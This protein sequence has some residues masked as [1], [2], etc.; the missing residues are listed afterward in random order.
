MHGWKMGLS[1]CALLASAALS[2]ATDFDD[3][4]TYLM[5]G[6]EDAVKDLEPVLGA[7]NAEAALADA[8]V[9]R[10]GLR[11]TE[12]Y[13]AAKGQVPDAVQFA[14]D[15]QALVADVVKYIEQKD[16]AN[17]IA[18]ARKTAKNCQKC[19]DVYKP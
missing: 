11:W 17:A 12:D 7:S 19:H 2:A 5:Q 13:F 8:A 16:F 4:D 18:A 14:R 9:L 1:A 10:D 3:I 15:G 6:M